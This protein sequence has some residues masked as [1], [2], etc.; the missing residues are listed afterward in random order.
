MTTLYSYIRI[1]LYSLY[2]ILCALC[3]N[4][5]VKNGA[6]AHTPFFMQNEPNFL[7]SKM[8]LSHFLNNTFTFFHFAFALKNEPKQSQLKPKT[9]PIRGQNKANLTPFLPQGIADYP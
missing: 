3:G 4:F 6:G 9:N 5:V 7:K 8:T 2:Q 1:F